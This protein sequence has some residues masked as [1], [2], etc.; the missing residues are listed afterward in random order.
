MPFNIDHE[1]L[2]DIMPPPHPCHPD[3]NAVFYPGEQ[4]VQ[5]EYLCGLVS[6]VNQL[7]ITSTADLQLCLRKLAQWLEHLHNPKFTASHYKGAVRQ[8]ME[9]VKAGVDR[10]RAG[11]CWN[12]GEAGHHKEQCP[13]PAKRLSDH[14]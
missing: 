5:Q 3:P 1:L 9:N 12:C 11:Q 4:Q 7:D 6:D 10:Q 14:R 8:A 13:K 2:N